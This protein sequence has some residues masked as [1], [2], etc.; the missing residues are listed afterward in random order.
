MK[1][2]IT[3]DKRIHGFD[4]KLKINVV[5]SNSQILCSFFITEARYK[6]LLKDNIQ[7]I[8]SN[9][10][11]LDPELFN[12]L[13]NIHFVL[14]TLYFNFDLQLEYL[15]NNIHYFQNIN[16]LSR[17]IPSLVTK[18]PIN[19]STLHP[20]ITEELPKSYRRLEVISNKLYEKKFTVSD[21]K[22]AIEIFN[23]SY[24]QQLLLEN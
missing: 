10:I 22:K 21:Y 12:T 19:I 9:I 4:Q 3:F 1:N 15:L 16:G 2:A 23:D 14:G 17:Y 18:E 8:E 6:M 24:I 20:Q 13:S 11:N 5:E 7:L